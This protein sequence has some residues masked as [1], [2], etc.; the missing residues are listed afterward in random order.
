MKDNVV[1]V[2]GASSG[3]GKATA[4]EL[5][6]RGASVVLIARRKKCLDDLALKIK[7]IGGNGLSIQA[8]VTDAATLHTI[9]EGIYQ[10]FGR[11]DA[12]INNAAVLAAGK[13]EEIP[14]KVFHRVFEVNF[15]GYVNGV[16]AVLPYLKKQGAGTIINVSSVVGVIGQPYT[17]PY[18]SSKFAI[19][20]F[21]EALRGELRNTNIK[22]C[23]VLPSSI[24][25]PIFHQAANFFGYKLQP[26]KPTYRA[27]KVANKIV[28]LLEK[29]KAQSCVGSIGSILIKA[30]KLAPNLIE[31]IFAAQVERLHFKDEPAALTEGNVFKPLSSESDAK[32]R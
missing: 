4:L 32:E 3:I 6:R 24:D 8:D 27:Q 23:T 26:L 17:L 7:K 20:G 25:T 15:F 31:R 28:G 19:N 30:H 11:I 16:R 10:R 21:S 13:F 22:L 5:G 29:P 18:T 9:A 14:P 2:T 12:W 1:V